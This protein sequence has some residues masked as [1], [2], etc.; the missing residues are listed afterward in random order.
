MEESIYSYLND[1]TK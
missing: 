1:A